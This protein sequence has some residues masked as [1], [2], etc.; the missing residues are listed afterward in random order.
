MLNARFL[1][2]GRLGEQAFATDAHTAQLKRDAVSPLLLERRIKAK[3]PSI[4]DIV[5][6]PHTSR[7]CNSDR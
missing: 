2:K 4:G 3:V 7:I 5:L 6:Q 1:P